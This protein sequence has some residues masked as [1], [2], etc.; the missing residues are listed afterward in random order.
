VPKEIVDIPDGWYHKRG[1]KELL[2]LREDFLKKTRNAVCTC[3]TCIDVTRCDLAYDMY[4]TDGD[5]L[6]EK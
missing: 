3:D 2:P 1:V 5:C 6:L 4:N